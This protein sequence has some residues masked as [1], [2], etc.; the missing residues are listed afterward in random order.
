[1]AAADWEKIRAEYIAGGGS[2]RKLAEKYGVSQ[3]TMRKKA[4]A[5]KW[6]EFKHKAA[7]EVTQKVTQKIVQ[8]QASAVVDDLKVARYTAMLFQD[9]LLQV[10]ELV[11]QNPNVMIADTQGLAHL[12]TAI[13]RNADSLMKT[14]RILNAGEARRLDIEER[15]LKL[16]EEKFRAEQQAREQGTDGIR[17]VLD[18][19]EGIDVG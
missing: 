8:K 14:C 9:T 11:C 5:G 2:Y 7:L 19:P 12:A 10:A 18:L 3:D 6:R 4:A 16:E 17:V 13:N 1:M 15:K